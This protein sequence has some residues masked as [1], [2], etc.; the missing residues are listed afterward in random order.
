MV[1]PQLLPYNLSV[2]LSFNATFSITDIFTSTKRILTDLLWFF[3]HITVLQ[4]YLPLLLASTQDKFSFFVSEARGTDSNNSDTAEGAAAPKQDA[5]VIRPMNIEDSAGPC[6]RNI[7]EEPHT[8][9]WP[10]KCEAVSTPVRMECFPFQYSP[11]VTVQR[12]S[13]G[14]RS[15]CKCYIF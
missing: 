6:D 8:S 14:R 1:I 11:D 4:T 9:E 12:G 7:V 2:I 15:R 10:V 3:L 13:S 5:L